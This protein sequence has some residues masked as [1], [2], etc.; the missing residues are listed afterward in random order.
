MPKKRRKIDEAKLKPIHER[1]RERGL[2]IREL[3]ANGPSTIPELSRATRL[4]TLKV[5]EHI[6]ALNQLG[7]ITIV[8]QKEDH[9]IYDLSK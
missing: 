8:G 6:I 3:K 2:I 1:N 9:F 5:V 4:E 7:R